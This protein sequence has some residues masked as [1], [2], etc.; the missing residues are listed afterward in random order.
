MKQPPPS[1]SHFIYK[2][3]HSQCLLFEMEQDQYLKPHRATV[4]IMIIAAK[5]K[6]EIGEGP[7]KRVLEAGEYILFAKDVQHSVLALTNA[8]FYL[9]KLA[10]H[11]Q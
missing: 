5:G 9:I 1:I 8:S 7:E 4:D 10:P 11:E 2:G 3:Q 6:L